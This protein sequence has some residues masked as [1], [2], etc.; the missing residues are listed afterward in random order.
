MRFKGISFERGIS[1][2]GKDLIVYIL[3]NDLENVSLNKIIKEILLTE[4][5]L[6]ARFGVGVDT[7]RAWHKI[8][9]INGV[10][11]IG[12]SVYYYVDT[13]DPRDTL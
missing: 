4:S 8:K 1:M 10:V 12:D 3:Q 13:P 11:T 9:M 6:A 2:T 5:Q 7:I